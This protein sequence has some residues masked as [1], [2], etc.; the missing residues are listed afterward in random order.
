MPNQIGYVLVILPERYMSILVEEMNVDCIDDIPHGAMFS[1]PFRIQHW[2]E[3]SSCLT[4]DYAR[5]GLEEGA[6]SDTELLLPQAYADFS[7]RLHA[8]QTNENMMGLGI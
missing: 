6:V 7:Y 8:E 2:A 1:V 4:L 5:A 3:L